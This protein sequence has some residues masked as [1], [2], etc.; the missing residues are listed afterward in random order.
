[1]APKTFL[2]GMVCFSVRLEG[3]EIEAKPAGL[4]LQCGEESDMVPWPAAWDEL[5]EGPDPPRPPSP[6][7]VYEL[8]VEYAIFADALVESGGRFPRNSHHE[9][10]IRKIDPQG[11]QWEISCNYLGKGGKGKSKGTG[12]RYSPY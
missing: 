4:N 6:R 7:M 9:F 3:W 2:H 5:F 11:A 10:N 12:D 8:F 1:M